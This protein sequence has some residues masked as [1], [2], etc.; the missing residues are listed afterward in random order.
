VCS[1]FSK[2]YIRVKPER[3]PPRECAATAMNNYQRRRVLLWAGTS[4]C[5]VL[6]ESKRLFL[7]D[8]V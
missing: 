3:R 8:I 7:I 2:T 5:A 6:L 1:P 4:T